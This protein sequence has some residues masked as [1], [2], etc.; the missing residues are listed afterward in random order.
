MQLEL[1][2]PGIFITYI[3]WS[4]V[5]IR[6][7]W[8]NFQG[9]RI[10]WTVGTRMYVLHGI[11]HLGS[12]VQLKCKSRVASVHARVPRAYTLLARGVGRVKRR[13]GLIDDSVAPLTERE[14]FLFQQIDFLPFDLIAPAL[15][16]IFTRIP[17]VQL[18]IRCRMPATAPAFL[19]ISVIFSLKFNRSYWL[20]GFLFGH[21]LQSYR[22]LMDQTS[23]RITETTAETTGK[24]CQQI[25][26]CW[27]KT[28]KRKMAGV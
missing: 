17:R 6:F 10:I 11:N 3:G 16:P 26:V 12:F 27:L 7:V 1:I 5:P 2:W 25:N 15:T 23:G 24:A 28:I 4:R 21:V 19:L 18:V 8:F 14:I 9:L 13:H 22:C 20:L